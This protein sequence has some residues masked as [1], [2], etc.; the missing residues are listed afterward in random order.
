MNI[1]FAENP[2]LYLGIGFGVFFAV[3]FTIKFVN[4]SKKKHTVK[5]DNG[6]VAFD[7]KNSG[8]ITTNNERKRSK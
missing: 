1:S 2:T 3:L 7:G 8:Q 5:A 6:S 4:K